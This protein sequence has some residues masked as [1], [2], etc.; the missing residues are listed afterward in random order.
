MLT[1]TGGQ[2][3]SHGFTP[4]TGYKSSYKQGS[5]NTLKPRQNGYFPDEI[6]KCVFLN[7]NV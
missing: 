2:N 4:S 6:F 3:R 1:I 7:E 5:I